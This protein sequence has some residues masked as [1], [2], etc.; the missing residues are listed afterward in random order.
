ML[1][2]RRS[3]IPPERGKHELPEHRVADHVAEVALGDVGGLAAG[4]AG[5]VRRSALGREHRAEVVKRRVP[6]LLRLLRQAQDL[7]RRVVEVQQQVLAPAEGR[8]HVQHAAQVRQAQE[9]LSLPLGK[10][11]AV[12]V[13]DA[14]RPGVFRVVADGDL[15]D[16]ALLVREEPDAA[17]GVVQPGAAQRREH[18]RPEGRKVHHREG[19]AE[20]GAAAELPVDRVD[21]R[22]GRA[23]H[24]VAVRLAERRAPGA[25]PSPGRPS[26]GGGPAR[27]ATTFRARPGPLPCGPG[28]SP[29][30]CAPPLLSSCPRGAASR[31]R[32]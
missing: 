12:E 26:P 6:R 27:R 23:V 29:R 31:A 21:D 11:G 13:L 28:Q 5:P 18:P 1:W 14:A 30:P 22:L 17:G 19:V 16:R 4:Q 25:G 8:H 24:L 20:E 32:A 7:L 3:T 15:L 10:P 9:H 2:A